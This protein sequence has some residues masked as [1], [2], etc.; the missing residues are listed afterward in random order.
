MEY[1]KDSIQRKT[2]LHVWLDLM[3]YMK[4]MIKQNL[5]KTGLHIRQDYT[6]YM[7]DRIAFKI[8]FNG[9]HERQN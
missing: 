9:I 5:Q 8:G 3:E 2:G 4:G 7:K 1:M 6:E